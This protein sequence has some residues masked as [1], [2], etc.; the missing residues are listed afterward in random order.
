MPNSK[1]TVA[2]LYNRVASF[3]GGVGPNF[4]QHCGRRSVELAGVFR[5]ARLLDVACGRGASLFPAIEASGEQGLC[6]GVDFAWGML[7]ETKKEARQQ[8]WEGAHVI[9]MDGDALGFPSNAFDFVLCGFAIFFFRQPDLTLQEWKRVLRRDGKLVVCVVGR[10]D[11]RWNW[12]NELLVA[13]H[14]R[15][16]F[17][18]AP[19]RNGIE[20]NKPPDIQAEMREAGFRQS[21]ILTEDYQLIYRDEREWWDSKWTHG[22]RFAL[23]NMPGEVFEQF[24]S[25]A[26]TELPTLKQPDGFHEHW[27][28]AWV[29]GI[30]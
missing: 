20:L 29:M 1:Q 4:F 10:S 3:Y 24:H 7:R 18:I 15:Y 25:E 23:E 2:D 14:E 17:P 6:V 16:G 11:E 30:K 21:A 5:G 8:G 26:L 12:F 19:M 22:S 28:V 9:Q 27:Q 13:Y